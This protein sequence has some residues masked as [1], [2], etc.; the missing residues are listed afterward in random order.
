MVDQA[1][2]A[3]GELKPSN[4]NEIKEFRI[5]PQPVSDVL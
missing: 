3:V 2:A 4:L 5:P 1:K